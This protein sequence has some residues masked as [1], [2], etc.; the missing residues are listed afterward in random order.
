MDSS[1]SLSIV[2]LMLL[3]IPVLLF[4][5]LT[6]RLIVIYKGNEIDFTNRTFTYVGSRAL[7]DIA[8]IFNWE[9]T[10]PA[11]GIAR[12]R[13]TLD[14][15]YRIDV[16]NQMSIGGE[17]EKFYCLDFE[18]AF[19]AARIK[20]DSYNQCNRLYS[21]LREELNMGTPVFKSYE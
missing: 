6:A 10:G 8:D 11:L 20:F 17:K 2:D 18:G 21:V 4:F 3:W 9:W 1:A 14:D 19:G 13:I 12:Q 5:Y 7:N 15:I 16:I